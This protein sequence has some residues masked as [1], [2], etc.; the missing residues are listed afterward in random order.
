MPRLFTPARVEL[1]SDRGRAQEAAIRRSSDAD[2]SKSLRLTQRGWNGRGLVLSFISD[3]TLQAW[4]ARAFT[5]G[6]TLELTLQANVYS[7]CEGPDLNDIPSTELVPQALR[8]VDALSLAPAQFTSL[9]YWEMTPC[10]VSDRSIS[11]GARLTGHTV[12]VRRRLPQTDQ[13]LWSYFDDHGKPLELC[14]PC[15][16]SGLAPDCTQCI[17][18]SGP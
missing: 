16:T 9:D 17:P 4:D 8:Q 18:E 15:V 3:S 14:G 10:R 13:Y 6:G 11:S 5:L 2:K 12:H 1:A 7:A